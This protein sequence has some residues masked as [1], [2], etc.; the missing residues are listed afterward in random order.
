MRGLFI[1]GRGAGLDLGMQ[2]IELIGQVGA[3]PFDARQP[4]FMVSQGFVQVVDQP[5]LM[6]Q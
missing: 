2:P 1:L 3:L 6:S 5:L 4:R